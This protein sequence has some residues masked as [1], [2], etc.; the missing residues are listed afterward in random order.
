MIDEVRIARVGQ[1]GDG[2][3]A[4][5]QA[6]PFTLPGERVSV[7]R[8]EDTDRLVEV[9]GPSPDR[10]EPPCPH[11]GTCG[12]CAL[13]HWAGAPYL[14]WKRQQVVQA[15][16]QQGLE[17]EV[18]PVRPVA[19][20]TRRRLVLTARPTPQ[21]V[22]LGFHAR[23]THDLV[24]LQTCKVATPK[25]AKRLPVLRALLARC[26]LRKEARVTVLDTQEGLDVTIEG[27]RPPQQ[28]AA[29][30]RMTEIC[31]R[32]GVLRVTIE[33][34]TVVFF[35]EPT[36]TVP[37][38]GT[39]FPPPGAFTQAV[40]DA[41]V[42]MAERV[43][44][45]VAKAKSIIELHAGIGTFTLHLA[46]IGRVTAYESDGPACTAL[47]RALAGNTGI[48]RGRAVRRDL[49]QAPLSA[50]EMK[51]TDALVLDPPRAGAPAQMPNLV[52]SKIRTVAYVSCNPAT[53][54]RDARVLV[55]GGFTLSRVTPLDQFLW[56][57]HI[58]LVGAF[59]R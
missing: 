55:D 12:G 51:K 33:G 27:A 14:D 11:F 42:E 58:E 24:D 26:R 28:G 36:L 50:D 4:D 23:A 13:Q 30:A 22:I 46:K 2:I 49:H 9:I 47:Q 52:A 56:S 3:G 32:S 38:S 43:S 45:I 39:T 59:E 10:V 6:V 19:P 41:E 18:D 31:R 29:L 15:L 40:R 25:I 21:G 7:D 34:E 8:L 37:A 35:K 57:P 54:A 53:F 17:T 48:K 44:E 5:G 16:A 1:R 20:L